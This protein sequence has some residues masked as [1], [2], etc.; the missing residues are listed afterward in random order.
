MPQASTAPVEVTATLWAKPADIPV[1]LVPPGSLTLTGTSLPFVL[2]LP[3]WPTMFQP[4]AN[5]TPLEL[6]ARPW[7]KPAAT[8]ALFA[9]T[10]AP[11]FRPALTAA[12]ADAC[13]ATPGQVQVT[14]NAPASPTTLRASDRFEA[15]ARRRVR[16]STS[17]RCLNSHPLGL[18]EI[19]SSSGGVNRAPLRKSNRVGVT[20][21]SHRAQITAPSRAWQFVNTQSIGRWFGTEPWEPS[22]EMRR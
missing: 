14:T 17:L 6:S 22:A 10:G 18:H 19:T 7:Y 16:D 15:P 20:R 1:T 21:T 5:T 4:Q 2:P 3:S 9:A 8:A 12:D 13:A 11:R